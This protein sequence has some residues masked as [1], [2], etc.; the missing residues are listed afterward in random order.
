MDQLSELWRMIWRRFWIIAI[1]AGLGL[2]LVALYAYLKIPVY[3]AEAKI[4]VES[5]SIPDDLA[6]SM[7]TADAAER[8]QLI[9]QRLMARDNL[10][11][12][13][14]DLDLYADRDDLT[15]T[16][17]VDLVRDATGIIPITLNGRRGRARNAVLSAFVIRVIYEQPRK[18]AELANKLS[19]VVLEQNIESRSERARTTTNF[20]AQEQERLNREIID[21]EKEITEFKE[22]NKDALPSSLS[23][24]Q[25]ELSRLGD[26]LLALDQKLLE[27][28]EERRTIAVKLEAMARM[29]PAAAATTDE[30]RQLR[31]LN[32]TLIQKQ[33]VLAAT[34]PEIRSLK[35]QIAALEAAITARTPAEGENARV[36]S[37]E[38]ATLRS[39]LQRLEG[40]MK[41]AQT[42][43]VDMEQRRATLEETL[44]RTPAIEIRLNALGRRLTEKQG[45]HTQMTRKRAEAETAERLEVNQQAERFEVIETAI[46]PTDPIALNRRKTVIMGSG[47]VVFLAFGLAFLIDQMRPRIRSAAQLERQLG[48]RPV[49]ALPYVRTR[50]ERRRRFA[51]R[52]SVMA[53]VLLGIPAGLWAIDQYYKPLP[54]LAEQL[55][56]KSGADNLLRMIEKRL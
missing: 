48:L 33:A 30:V 36:M 45:M 6:R 37:A 25:A 26:A 3:Q 52:G 23:F 14:Q 9:K 7:V 42:Q 1:V 35:N 8:L 56:E 10:V 4:L 13:I 29:G 50:A 43:K 31:T 40:Q 41:L 49:V 19:D 21:L 11:K 17:K 15:L 16:E 55:A 39:R 18:A 34:H 24:R 54:L 46:P 27:H 32:S 38:E 12:F 44:Q 47:L 28:E 2:P 51:R 22:K 53:L 5:Q 20:F